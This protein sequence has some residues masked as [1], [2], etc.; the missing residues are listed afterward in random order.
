MADAVLL[1][2][3]FAEPAGSSR[4]VARAAS[5][6][7]ST[8]RVVRGRVTAKEAWFDLEYSGLRRGLRSFIELLRRAGAAVWTEGGRLTHQFPPLSNR[9]GSGRTLYGSSTTS[10]TQL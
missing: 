4:T 5:G 2:L 9:R 10:T 7:K 8:V 3:K 6:R 1:R